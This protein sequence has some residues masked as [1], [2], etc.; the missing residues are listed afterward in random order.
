[1]IVM[2]CEP[3]AVRQFLSA[4]DEVAAVSQMPQ[5]MLSLP[6]PDESAQEFASYYVAVYETIYSVV[7]EGK[8][9]L[10]HKHIRTYCILTKLFEYSS[11]IARE[12]VMRHINYIMQFSN[13]TYE[14]KRG[15]V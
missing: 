15:I 11:D 1:M 7:M 9:R 6:D 10:S 14:A 13:A 4:L 2:G 3:E 8:R 12:E 5:G